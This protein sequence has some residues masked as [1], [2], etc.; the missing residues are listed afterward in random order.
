MCFKTTID[1]KPERA[2]EDISC[3]KILR[4]NYTPFY[5]TY[6][7][8]YKSGVLNPTIKLR[9][10]KNNY[11][12][13]STIKKGYHSYQTEKE[14]IYKLR[15]LVILSFTPIVKNLFLRVKKLY[16]ICHICLNTLNTIGFIFHLRKKS[17]F[18][19]CQIKCPP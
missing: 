4:T 5:Y 14:A 12:I 3:W 2:K 6:N 16:F 9:K 15:R 7:L 18:H 1:A 11:Y 19:L 13:I 10:T 17:L 8:P